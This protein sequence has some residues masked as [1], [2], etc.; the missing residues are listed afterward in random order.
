LQIIV[1]D[2]AFDLRRTLGLNYSEF[3]NS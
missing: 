1:H 3:P 2:L